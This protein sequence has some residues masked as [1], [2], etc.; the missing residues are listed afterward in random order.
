VLFTDTETSR[1][2]ALV[3]DHARAWSKGELDFVKRFA[4]AQKP[5]GYDTCTS[6]MAQR[7]RGDGEPLLRRLANIRFPNRASLLQPLPLNRARQVAAAD[8]GVYRIPPTVTVIDPDTGTPVDADRAQAFKVLM[9]SARIDSL[10]PEVERRAIAVHTLFAK[11]RWVKSVGAGAGG[12]LKIDTFWPSD[13]AVVCHP[14]DPGNFDQAVIILARTSRAG[15]STTAA[16]Y[17]LWVRSYQD[18]DTGQPAAFDPWHVHTVSSEGEYLLPPSDPRTMFADAAGRPLPSP[19][20]IIQMGLADGSVYVDPDKDLPLILDHLSLDASAEM[21]ARDLQAF[22]PVIYAGSQ[23]KGSELAWGPG[24][25][26]E[27]GDDE[28][29]T[30]LALDP[31]LQEMRDGR[32]AIERELATTRRNNPNAYVAAPGPAES[33]ISRLIQEA[34][35]EAVLDENQLVF[36]VWEETQLLPACVMV[37]DAFSGEAPIGP[38]RFDVKMRRPHPFEE[39]ESRQRRLQ[40][41]VDAGLITPA[42]MAVDLEHYDTIEDAVKAGVSNVLKKAPAMPPGLGSFG[43]G[44]G[45]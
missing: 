22:T 45:F 44:G 5:P 26:T 32:T 31:K 14:S 28:T 24:E 7:Y 30:T 29:M 20:T 11:P 1:L 43:G 39:P 10:R 35:H 40:A 25:V 12:R 19:W 34:P 4:E 18:D 15:V 42:K 17:Q 6:E 33:G 16:W 13:V 8:S 27:I 37:H 36:Q 3:S 23:R 41:D 38:C 9:D 21:L 2:N